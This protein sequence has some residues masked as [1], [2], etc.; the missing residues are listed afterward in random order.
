M[1]PAGL[2]EV[3]VRSRGVDA[4]DRVRLADPP[5]R[6]AAIGGFALLVGMLVYMA[7]Q[8]PAR[9]TLFPRIAALDA[10][11]GGPGAWLPSF[12]H[13]FAFSLLTA[14]ALERSASPA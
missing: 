13:P 10:L 11:L 6:L 7:D 9:A 2:R 12:V 8:D 3:V 1:Q 5:A 14:A 4:V